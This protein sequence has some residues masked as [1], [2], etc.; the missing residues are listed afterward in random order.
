M[1]AIN[2]GRRYEIYDDTLKVYDELPANTYR[3]CFE[4][5]SG[6]YLAKHTDI[7]VTEKIYGIH[8]EKANKV[9]R[10]F[11]AF[12]RSLGVILSG[13]KG[14]GKS[15]FAKRLCEK[16]VAAGYPVLILD[17]FIPGVASY[18]ESIDQEVVVLFDEFD[19]TFGNIHVGE[20]E[21]NPQ[22]GLLSL[23]DGV[24]CGK[25]L[26]V[27]TCN[28]LRGLND[29]LVNR[30]GRFHYHFRFE[31]PSDAEIREYLTDKLDKRYYG[32]ID[33]VIGFSKRV[34]LNFDCLRAIAFELNTGDPFERAIQDLNILN[35]Q[36]EKYRVTLHFTDGTSLINR[37]CYIDLFDGD[38][39]Y[40]IALFD[41]QNES[42]CDVKFN[43]ENAVY[44]STRGSTVV[45][46]N[47]CKLH[48]WDD[49]EDEKENPYRKKKVNYLSI[50]HIYDRSLHYTAY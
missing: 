42:I 47:E 40:D 23:F 43:T 5:M 29:Y 46:G 37:K 45:A 28:E 26:F 49:E 10:S 44:D 32:E 24:A 41:K 50:V 38:T 16:A 20:N 33:K 14:I 9:L 31:Y 21:A 8:E 19:K 36:Q 6:F 25:K 27:I 22:A 7:A 17:Q 13:N 15:L 18:L 4:K 2:I 34:N 48:F 3:I 30:P 11:A 39:E 12:E 1:K 35:L